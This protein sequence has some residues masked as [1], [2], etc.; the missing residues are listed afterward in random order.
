MVMTVVIYTR[1]DGK[2]VS[3][4]AQQ[5]DITVGVN[6]E[7]AF[8]G[9]LYNNGNAA[10][11]TI[12]T[13]LP[14]FYAD[15]YYLVQE[16]VLVPVMDDPVI[17]AGLRTKLRDAATTYCG[18]LN[19]Q[20]FLYDFPNYGAHL[21]QSD[22]L[23]YLRWVGL[24]NITNAKI[25][26]GHGDSN[27]YMRVDKYPAGTGDVSLSLTYNQI[28]DALLTYGENQTLN[29]RVMWVLKD[30]S[31][32]ASRVELLALLSNQATFVTRWN[33]ERQNIIGAN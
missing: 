33:A 9:V 11:A 27:W 3:T 2:I 13:T 21:I 6:G 20:S 26:L 7:W 16:G 5:S 8:N 19:A 25:A 15:I 24:G 23:S 10:L 30:W 4:V 28:R 1:A 12:S 22:Q 31:N 17:V 29:M 14:A 18:Y 32:D